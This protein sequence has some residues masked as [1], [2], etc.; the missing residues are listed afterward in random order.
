MISLLPEQMA[1]IQKVL[2]RN[3]KKYY[4]SSGDLHT[5]AGMVPEAELQQATTKVTAKSGK[6]LHVMPA[7]FKDNLEKATRGPQSLLEKDVGLIIAHTAIDKTQTVLEA[8]TG[9]GLLTAYL[10]RWAKQVISYD[11]NKEHQALAQ[12]NLDLL[13]IKNVELKHADIAQ[14]TVEQEV[15]VVIL[16]LPEPEFAA[17]SVHKALK[18]GGYVVIYVPS[19]VQV[20]AATEAYKQEF[21]IEKTVELLEREWYV[22]EKKVRPKSDMQAHTAFMIFARK[23]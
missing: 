22:D 21:L 20:M 18:Q 23:I 2:L 9:S 19:V 11:I 8:G 17:K 6:E 7:N 13:D 15:D 14:V 3:N 12:K 5:D 4:W 16:D 10:A 1:K